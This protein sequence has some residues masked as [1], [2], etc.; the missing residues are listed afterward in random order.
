MSS[1][2]ILHETMAVP[3]DVRRSRWI[4]H[5]LCKSPCMLVFYKWH[6]TVQVYLDHQTHPQAV[7]VMLKEPEQLVVWLVGELV[8]VVKQSCRH[9]AEMQ[10]SQQ[11]MPLIL[12][13]WAPVLVCRQPQN[14]CL[15]YMA[16]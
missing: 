8:E 3:D 13:L 10:V 7:Q 12:L 4:D 11:L 14:E 16:E 9:L 6:S 2:L 1:P 5:R 15:S